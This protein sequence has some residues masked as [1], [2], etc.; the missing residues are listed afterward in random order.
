[1]DEAGKDRERTERV[2][3]MA[4][5][6]V[7]PLYVKKAERKGRTKAEVDEVIAWLT[8]YSYEDIE[9]LAADGT[10][11]EAFFARA[12]R[13]NPNAGKIT[14]LICGVRVG[15]IAD[16]VMRDVRRLDKL[17]DELA[18]GRPM[19]KVLRE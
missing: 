18:K 1:M 4:F 15:E 14:G 11:I 12:P 3:R 9:R 8:G 16:P 5:G 7:Y 6:T 2:Y 10:D 13:M 17:I 19:E